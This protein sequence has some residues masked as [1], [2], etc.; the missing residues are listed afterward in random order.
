MLSSPSRVLS[1][2]PKTPEISVWFKWKGPFWLLATRIFRITW[3]AGPLISVGIF[4]PKFTVPYLIN[5][6]FALISGSG[7]EIKTGKSYSYWLSKFNWELP[8]Y[9]PWV[10]LLISDWSVWHNGKHPYSLLQI[11]DFSGNQ[12]EFSY[13]FYTCLPWFKETLLIF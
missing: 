3:G 1:I 5:Q 4:L 11:L 12:S 8:F 2:M 7:I 9:F 10:F 13:P 6:F